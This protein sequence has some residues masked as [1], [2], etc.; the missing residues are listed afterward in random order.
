MAKSMI[1]K[2]RAALED[3]KVA[4]G[5]VFAQLLDPEIKD[6]LLTVEEK[7]SARQKLATVF[8]KYAGQ[9]SPVSATQPATLGGSIR[10]GL[11]ASQR[12]SA[13]SNVPENEEYLNTAT[14]NVVGVLPWWK[15]ASHFPIMQS[16][17]RDFLAVPA[18]SVQSERENS[19]AKYV[20]TD[21]RNRLSSQTVQASLCLKSWNLI[22]QTETSNGDAIALE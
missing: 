9:P 6:T 4:D 22:L 14:V 15:N 1:P 18:S 10:A 5:G 3:W 16:L 13:V 2:L 17:A 12:V 21:V 8:A 11:I 20:V 7:A 19:K